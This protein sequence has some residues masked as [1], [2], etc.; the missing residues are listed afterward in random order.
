MISSL[1]WITAGGR[2]GLGWWPH[3]LY[4]PSKISWKRGYLKIVGKLTIFRGETRISCRAWIPSGG[5]WGRSWRPHVLVVVRQICAI[6]L[7]VGPRWK[8]RRGVQLGHRVHLNGYKNSTSIYFD[9]RTA[10]KFP[11]RNDKNPVI[12]SCTA[13]LTTNFHFYYIIHWNWSCLVK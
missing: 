9:W 5:R 3:V 11:K 10:E 4:F 13:D 7:A 1:A 6:G 8:G 12:L 2:W